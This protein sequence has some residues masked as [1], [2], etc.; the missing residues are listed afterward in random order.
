M[1]LHRVDKNPNDPN[2]PQIGHNAPRRPKRVHCGLEGPRGL[3]NRGSYQPYDCWPLRLEACRGSPE[4]P[5]KCGAAS[6]LAS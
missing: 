2:G 5:G 1:L 6:G 4:T 3:L